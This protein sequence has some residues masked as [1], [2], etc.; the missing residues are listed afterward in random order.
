MLGEACGPSAIAGNTAAQTT[1]RKK[2]RNRIEER[3]LIMC[4]TQRDPIAAF[5][6]IGKPGGSQAGKV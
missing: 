2:S 5:G 4:R 3:P 6:P 1:A